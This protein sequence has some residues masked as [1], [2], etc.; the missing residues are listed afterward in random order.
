MLILLDADHLLTFAFFDRCSVLV[1]TLALLGSIDLARAA[2]IELD[3]LHFFALLK[4]CRE[5]LCLRFTGHCDLGLAFKLSARD[6][7]VI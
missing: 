5:L 6:P 2:K 1:T 4:L 7:L 3:S